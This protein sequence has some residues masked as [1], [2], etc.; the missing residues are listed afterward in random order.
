MHTWSA[1]ESASQ[2]ATSTAMI[3]SWL[4][5]T[6]MGSDTINDHW[7]FF[8]LC[9]KALPQFQHDF[10]RTSWS[11]ALPMSCQV[12]SALLASVL[13]FAKLCGKVFLKAEQPQYCAS[14]HFGHSL[15]RN[16]NRPRILIKSRMKCMYTELQMSFVPQFHGYAHLLPVLPLSTISSIRAG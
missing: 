12:I 13:I 5:I 2:Q 3:E 14:V 10:L 7:M 1:A 15:F 4:C 6:M 16:F 9:N 11:I 8:I